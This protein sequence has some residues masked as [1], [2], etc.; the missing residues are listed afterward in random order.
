MESKTPWTDERERVGKIRSSSAV[1]GVV[2]AV[3]VRELERELAEARA[4]IERLQLVNAKIIA[5]RAWWAIK[6]TD[7]T[8]LIKQMSAALRNVI[9][10]LEIMSVMP[11]VL[12]KRPVL[13]MD[14]PELEELRAA[15][16]AAEGATT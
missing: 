9:G 6:H 1:M 12:G 11:E 3:Y 4:E 10:V 7:A 16:R 15:L 14:A 13:A 5:N 2:P 8:S